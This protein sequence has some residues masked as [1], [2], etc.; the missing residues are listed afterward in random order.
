MST[1]PEG[2]TDRWMHR[3]TCRQKRPKLAPGG[4]EGY[5]WNS[6][7][8][9]RWASEPRSHPANATPVGQQPFQ[10]IPGGPTGRV[11]LPSG[12]WPGEPGILPHSYLPFS[13]L[14]DTPNDST[15]N[16]CREER[17]KPGCQS[18]GPTRPSH[19]NS[20][21]ASPQSQEAAPWHHLNFQARKL[22]V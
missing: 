20:L 11:S 16:F 14:F 22:R 18:S 4:T 1:C 17:E 19:L 13:I 10:R 5:E 2:W 21:H 6:V 9:A 8:K 7:S 12:L 15:Q 3:H